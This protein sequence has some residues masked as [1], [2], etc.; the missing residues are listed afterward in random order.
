MNE[1]RVELYIREYLINKG[2]VIKK[3]QKKKGE[4]GVDI[5]ASHPKWRKTMYIE[6]KG[7]SGKH[8]YQEMHGAFY[9]LLGQC[10]WRMDKEGNNPNKARIYA[11]G[12][13]YGWIDVFRNKIRKM[14]YGWN[15]LKLKTFLVRKDGSVLEKPHSFFMK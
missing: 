7:G 11:I 8:K 15:L 12:I 10:L 14:K 9:T 1:S 6:V 2:W 5:Y 4:H 13:P 3:E